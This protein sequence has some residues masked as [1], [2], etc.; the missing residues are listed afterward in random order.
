MIKKTIYLVRH[1]Q[2]ADNSRSLFQTYDSPLSILG[3]EQAAKLALRLSSHHFNTLLTSNQLRAT[4][5]ADIISERIQLQPEPS[6]LFVERKKPTSIS[7]KSHSDTTAT[8]TWRAWEK[9][10]YT[11]G[12]KIEDG[13]NYDEIME[14]SQRALDFLRL[15]PEENILVVSHGYFMRA[16][17]VHVILGDNATP[18][19]VEHFQHISSTANTGMIVLQYA[20]AFEED[21][22][23]RIRSFNDAAHLG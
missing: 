22:C 10:L 19:T 20:D 13:E 11:P 8:K 4:Q 23:W 2:S 12:A 21:F 14:R 1:G 7:G 18:K 3:K 15:R 5:T 9:S 17:T 16:M 6:D